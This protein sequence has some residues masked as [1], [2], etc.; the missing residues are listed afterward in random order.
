MYGHLTDAIYISVDLDGLDPSIMPATGTP[1]PGGLMWDE[2][3][4]ILTEAC[5]Q[6]RVV[7]LD[8]VELQPIP[9]MSAPQVLAAR[10]LYR[11]MGLIAGNPSDY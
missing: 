1:E 6:R 3:W 11:L 5:T 8:V 4:E 2:I 7:G 10:L 9:G